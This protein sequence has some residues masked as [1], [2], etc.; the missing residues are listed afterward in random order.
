MSSLTWSDYMDIKMMVISL[1]RMRDQQAQRQT[2]LAMMLLARPPSQPEPE[3]QRQLWLPVELWDI[4]ALEFL[5][6]FVVKKW[7]K[8]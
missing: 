8:L 1:E 6:F 2:M 5:P 7:V 3:P 4:V